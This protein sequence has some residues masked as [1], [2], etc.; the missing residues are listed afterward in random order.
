[1][2]AG[3][4]KPDGTY[5]K[6]LRIAGTLRDLQAED[7]TGATA[8]TLG[9]AIAGSGKIGLPFLREKDNF[10]FAVQYG[11]GYGAQIK[12]GPNDAAFNP[13][14]S[15]LETI[16]VFSTYGGFQH[17]WTDSLRSNFVYGYVDAKN[18]EFITGDELKNTTYAAADL[19]WNP[20]EMV[21][22]GFE[23]LWGS[24]ENKDGKTGNS[25]RYLFSSRINF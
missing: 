4:W 9:W 14:D 12:S 6:H 1:M 21:T 18:P 13:V 24:L 7:D 17:W 16:G 23:Y 25:N 11:E 2:L 22:L 15:E 10:K 5:I 3:T 20:Y 19:I 8:S